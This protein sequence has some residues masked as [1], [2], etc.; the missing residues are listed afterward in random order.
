[1]DYCTAGLTHVQRGLW[2]ARAGLIITE[3]TLRESF[4]PALYRLFLYP[5]HR[6]DT[7]KIGQTCRCM[8]FLKLY[9]EISGLARPH[10]LS[11]C[12]ANEQT[13]VHE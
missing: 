6:P 11:C 3:F 9:L 1:V 10:T 2:S 7:E 4:G 5:L 13:G 8:G 12:P